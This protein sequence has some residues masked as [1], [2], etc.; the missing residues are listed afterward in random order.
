MRY[1]VELKAV[2]DKDVLDKITE[3]VSDDIH[4]KDCTIFQVTGQPETE[5]DETSGDRLDC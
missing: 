4:D 1:L 5:T 2:V 3:I